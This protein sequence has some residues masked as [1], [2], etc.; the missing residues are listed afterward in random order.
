VE[1]GVVAVVL[2]GQCHRLRHD[3]VCGEMHDRIDAMIRHEARDEGIVAHIA[4]H[5]FAR[6]DRLSETLAEIIQNDDSF[7]RLAQLPHHVTADISSTAGDQ[8]RSL[9]HH[10]RSSLSSP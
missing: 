4:H 10:P 9:R 3:G 5:Q 8:N 6:R 1:A 7:A 2:E